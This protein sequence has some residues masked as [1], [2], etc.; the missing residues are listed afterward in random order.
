MISNVGFL[1]HTSRAGQSQDK[2]ARMVLLGFFHGVR[3]LWM[4]ICNQSIAPLILY[5]PGLGH[6]HP[7]EPKMACT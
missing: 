5:A 4:I 2:D 7:F 3:N 1:H 6:F